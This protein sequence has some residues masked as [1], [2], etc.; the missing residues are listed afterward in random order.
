M[1]MKKE[2]ILPTGLKR[3]LRLKDEDCDFIFDDE[4][5]S[6]INSDE[7]TEL[8]YEGYIEVSVKAGTDELKIKDYVHQEA[9]GL[10]GDVIQDVHKLGFGCDSFDCRYELKGVEFARERVFIE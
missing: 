5:E 4:Y 2:Q 9:M 6:N 7:I 10:L 8:Y 3:H 1:A